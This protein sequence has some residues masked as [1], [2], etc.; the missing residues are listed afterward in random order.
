[1]SSAAARHMILL[2]PVRLWGESVVGSHPPEPQPEIRKAGLGL[3]AM[4][5]LALIL[6]LLLFAFGFSSSANFKLLK[7]GEVMV[8]SRT[9]LKLAAGF[10]VEKDTRARPLLWQLD[11]RSYG[12]GGA[13]VIGDLAKLEPALERS[14]SVN[15]ECNQHWDAFVTTNANEP[16]L[17]APAW[18]KGNGYCVAK[19]CWYRPGRATCAIQAPTPWSDGAQSMPSPELAHVDRLLGPNATIDWKVVTCANRAGWGGDDSSCAESQGIYNPSS[20]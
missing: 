16:K 10:A 19:R 13:C 2:S 7:P 18:G 15:A 9:P 5:V 17:D 12:S 8:T 1:M 20:L 6:L 4:A 11:S 14:C 3:R